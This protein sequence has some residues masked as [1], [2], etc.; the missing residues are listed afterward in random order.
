MSIEMAG[1]PWASRILS[2]VRI[3]VGLMLLQH[4]TAK[5]F[6][7]PHVAFFD[8]LQIA[9]L[10]GVAGIIELVFGVLFTVGLFTRLS[11]FILSGHL[12]AVYFL[13]HAGKGFF[14]L[15]NGGEIAVVYCFVFLYFACAGGGPWSLDAVLRNRD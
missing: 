3:M 4:A 5:L 15:L 13:G 8:K 2:V 1:A 14:P 9:S 11:A 12:A 6:G 10:I 7:V